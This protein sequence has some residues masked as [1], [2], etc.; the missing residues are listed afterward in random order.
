MKKQSKQYNSNTRHLLTIFFLIFALNAIGQDLKTLQMD[1]QNTFVEDLKER[2]KIADNIYRLDP[3]NETATYCLVKSYN[4]TKHLDSIPILFAKLKSK[5]ANSPLPYLLSAKYQY[6]EF[7]LSDTA[8]LAELK[9]AIKLDSNNFEAHYLLGASYYT[10]F[11]KKQTNDYA[12]KSRSHFVKAT[13]LENSTLVSLKYS[14]IQTSTFLMDTIY[15]SFFKG[16]KPEIL[17]DSLNILKSGTW[18]FPLTSF[19]D[20]ENNWESDYSLDL[21][22]QVGMTTSALDFYSRQL[23]ALKEPLIFNQTEKTIYR[24]TWLRSFNNPV[25]IRVEKTN[26]DY[27]LYWKQSSGTGGNNPG[28]LTVNNSKQITREEWDYFISLL[29]STDF[30][31]MSTNLKGDLGS[32]G[33]YW[34][35]EGIENNKYHVVE[36][37][38]PRKNNFQKCGQYLIELTDLKI[39]GSDIY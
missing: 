12:F 26:N 3:Y 8:R 16:I 9:T 34:I 18:Y 1:I 24:F 37:W 5:N 30:W 7:S 36:R 35:I 31:N 19:L 33:S 21:I 27:T 2:R 6:Q 25:A 23:F 32:D 20:L 13:Q 22:R 28:E 10:L 29:Q 38:S 17:K 11:N 4:Y 15:I 14:I 39:K